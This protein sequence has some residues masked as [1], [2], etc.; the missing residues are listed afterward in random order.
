MA[1]LL[2]IIFLITSPPPSSRETNQGGPFLFF[3]PFA[4]EQADRERRGNGDVRPAPYVPDPVTGRL[5]LGDADPARAI[6]DPDCR[7]RGT[8]D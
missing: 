4:E 7:V 5:S 1:F 2:K 3:R 8:A 6:R